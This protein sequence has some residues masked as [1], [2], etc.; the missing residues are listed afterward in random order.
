MIRIRRGD[1][2]YSDDEIEAMVEDVKY[3]KEH[4]ADGIVFGCLDDRKVHLEHSRKIVNAWGSEKPITF[5][6]AFDETKMEDLKENLNAL[7][8]LGVRRILTSGFEP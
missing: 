4:G 1:F 5:H 8:S 7:S 3:F 6:R 2:N